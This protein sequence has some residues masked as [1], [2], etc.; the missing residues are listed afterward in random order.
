M[1]NRRRTVLWNSAGVSRTALAACALV[2]AASALGQEAPPSQS[3]GQATSQGQGPSRAPGQGPGQ[4]PG[5]PNGN[6]PL[7]N[8]TFRPGFID[9]FNRWL[10]EGASKFKS[11]VQRAQDKVDSVVGLPS[12]RA[13]SGRERCAR[14]QNGAPDCQAAAVALCRGK[15]F[16]TGKSLDTQSEQK[17]PAQVLLRGRPPSEVECRTETFVTRALCQ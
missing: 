6:A 12:T 7:P 11:G 17:C 9:E 4:V 2:L 14:A 13:T 16:Q 15:G 3:P 5:D 10:E 8:S 1:T